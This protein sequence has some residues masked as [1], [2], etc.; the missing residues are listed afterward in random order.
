MLN[1]QLT[2]IIPT[3]ERHSLLLRA[4][5]Y[6]TNLN[7]HVIIVDSSVNKLK[8]ILT[9][10]FQYIHMPC[11]DFGSKIYNVISQVTTKYS[12]LSADDD[13]LS[14]S[15]LIKGID[16]LE[17]NDDY[18]SVQ[19]RYISFYLKNYKITS[20]P[21]Y[22]KAP[23]YLVDGKS[24]LE[25][26]KQAF[27][28]Y[29]HHMYSV[30]RTEVLIKSFLAVS[31][32]KVA[33]PVELS[34]ALV[35]AVYG[36][37]MLLPEFWMARDTNV[38]TSTINEEG[39]IEKINSYNFENNP[40]T[41]IV[42]NWAGYLQ[43]ADGKLF[44][45]KYCSVISDIVKDKAEQNALFDT[46]F[47]TYIAGTSNLK[48]IDPITKF[49]LKNN[50]KIL[51]PNY[52]LNVYRLIRYTYFRYKYPLGYPWSDIYSAKDWERMKSVI[53]KYNDKIGPY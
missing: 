34:V 27:S 38:Y 31:T 9:S 2:I 26:V 52:F 13:F 43:T 7:V 22:T 25:R 33:S 12:C 18:V 8:R 3:H 30:H 1:E 40:V 16:F 24:R 51:L 14:E 19:G 32:I 50:I 29:M 45:K 47:L 44:K 4:V 39:Q 41:L 28:P 15:G 36:K 20:G 23:Y 6:Y 35:G 46:G 49:N 37:H 48:N 11:E 21:M 53:L 17:E 5:D 10:K 42:K